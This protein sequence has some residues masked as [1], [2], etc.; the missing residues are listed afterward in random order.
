MGHKIPVRKTNSQ[1]RDQ[2]ATGTMNMNMENWQQMMMQCMAMMRG[3][4]QTQDTPAGFQIFDN[5][6]KRQKMLTGGESPAEAAPSGAHVST[7][8]ALPAPAAPSKPEIALPAAPSKPEMA[9]PAAPSKPEMAIPAAAPSVQA[10]PAAAAEAP[11]PAMLLSMEAVKKACKEREKEK[12]AEAAKAAAEAEEAE[13]G[14]D[15]AKSKKTPKNKAVKPKAKPELKSKSEDD[16]KTPRR[17]RPVPKEQ[18]ES[19]EKAAV[20]KKGDGTFFWKAGKVHRND[21]SGHW[22]CF[23]HRSD[24]TDKKIKLGKTA[25]EEKA[26][27][28]RALKWIEED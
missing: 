17:G 15:K 6:R 23:K 2:S 9:L 28:V 4:L 21:T 19:A 7:Q 14:G 3:Q 11:D 26:S 20:P 16:F 25:D 22:R 24:K 8:L 1:V 13:G 18:P 12:K 5:R 27:F 10:I